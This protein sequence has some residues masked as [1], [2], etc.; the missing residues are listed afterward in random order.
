MRMTSYEPGTPCW[1]DLGSPDPAAAADFYSGLFGWE[2]MEGPPEAGGYRMCLL[3]GAPVAGLGPQM[4]PEVRPYW[5][6]YV[7]VT[8][9]AAVAEQARAAG[10]EIL[11]EPLPVFDFGSMAV[12]R[13]PTGA[14][15]SIWQPGGHIGSGLFGEPGS[16]CWNE[17]TTRQAKEAIPFYETVFGWKAVEQPMG[18]WTYTEWHS[19]D[20]AV[21]GMMAMDETWPAEI[22]SHWMVYFA[23]EDVD[24]SAARVTELGGTVSVPPSDIPPGRFS[25]VTDPHGAVLSLIA[26]SEERRS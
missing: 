2:I 18:E 26:L 12:F 4:M 9:A 21:A 10:A 15:C 1:T 25:V 17:L 5:T 13:D 7:C 22:P 23:V 8:D 20:R 3:R 14:P 11:A 6:T 19:G 24:A 16:I